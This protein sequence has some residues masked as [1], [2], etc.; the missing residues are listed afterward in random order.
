MKKNKND[1]IEIKKTNKQEEKSVSVFPPF[2]IRLNMLCGIVHSHVCV[3]E[4]S[5]V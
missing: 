2:K 5:V 3:G 1:E 4:T